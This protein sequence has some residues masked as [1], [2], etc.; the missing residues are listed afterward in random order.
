M[1][2]LDEARGSAGSELD[3]MNAHRFLESMD[4]TL[5]VREMRN[6]LRD[7]DIVSR[8]FCLLSPQRMKW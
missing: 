8:I 5:T 1:V 7:I 2:E 6:V 3:E 4:E